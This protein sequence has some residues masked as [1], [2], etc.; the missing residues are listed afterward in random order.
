MKV[1]TAIKSEQIGSATIKS[2]RGVSDGDG[3]SENGRERERERERE[4]DFQAHT[5]THT[6]LVDEKGGDD[7]ANAAERVRNNVQQ[8]TCARSDPPCEL[9]GSV[10]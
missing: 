5:H 2:R 4:R 6:I 3:E 10:L 8:H 9:M 7:D 1:S